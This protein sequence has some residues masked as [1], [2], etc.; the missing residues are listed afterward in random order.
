[1]GHGL[2]GPRFRNTEEVQK[3]VNEWIAAKAMSFF[4]YGIAML[5]ERW[6]KVAASDGKYVDSHILYQFV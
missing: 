2:A 3:L 1:M 4:R 6:E 5:A